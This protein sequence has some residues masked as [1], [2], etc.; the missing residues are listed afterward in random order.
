M[1]Q[2]GSERSV[3]QA[4]LLRD[5][6]HGHRLLVFAKFYFWHGVFDEVEDSEWPL[7]PV[8]FVVLAGATSGKVYCG[9][10]QGVKLKCDPFSAPFPENAGHLKIGLPGRGIDYTKSAASFM[11]AMNC[12]GEEALPQAGMIPS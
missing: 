1:W 6:F 7:P 11:E 12:I 2:T 10:R 3:K 9:R 8:W 4:L 5:T